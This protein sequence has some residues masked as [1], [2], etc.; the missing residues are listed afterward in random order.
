MKTLIT[1]IL[2]LLL[3]VSAAFTQVAVNS[4]G[5]NPDAS[6]M[7]DVSSNSKGVLFPRMTTAQRNGITNP[8]KGLTVYDSTS[9]QLYI[10]IG[11]P[12]SPSWTSFSAGHLWSRSG[13]DTYLSNSGDQV[14][15]GISSPA[16]K[17]QVQGNIRFSGDLINQGSTIFTISSSTNNT[18][19]GATNN[20]T[21][22]GSN[23]SFFGVNAGAN[24]T[25]GYENTF[26][27][28]GAGFMNGIGH[29]NVFVGYDAGVT[30]T[31]GSNNVLLGHSAGPASGN[32]DHKLYIHSYSGTPLI[33]GDFNNLEVGINT[34]TP[35]TNFAIYESNTHLNPASLVEQ[36]G[37]GDAAQRFLLTQGQ[38]F[39]IG[40]DNSD[41]DN[42]RISSTV[43]LGSSSAYGEA[44]TMMRIHTENNQDGIIDFNHQSRARVWLQTDTI[45]IPSWVWKPVKFDQ[46]SFDEHG[47]WGIIPGTSSKF[48]ALEDGY[49][50]VNSR[51]EFLYNDEVGTPWCSIAIY[52][53]DTIYAQG[54][55]LKLT[56][57]WH[58]PPEQSFGTNNNAPN[59][60]D[61]LYLNAGD[62][63]EIYVFHTLGPYPPP[64]G[65]FLQLKT[66]SSQTY[67]SIHKIS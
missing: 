65:W 41:N 17:L 15:I 61:V 58:L 9:D 30:V 16:E 47:E 59:V 64:G 38:N 13:T 49:Y 52:V 29:K 40:V 63:V 27:G 25:S 28:S 45:W 37:A 4:S 21:N 36:A 54:N 56:M 22:S 2:S 67:C 39:C 43:N 12:A 7:L 5:T 48:T 26:L 53:N 31:T 35:G 23:N 66:G 3:I 19:V 10:N 24:N 33:Y 32:I 14:G 46:V 6:A 18:F 57:W 51:T 11:S 55:N 8:A 20:T 62:V 42:F 1:T 34:V 60:S 50:Q 44:S